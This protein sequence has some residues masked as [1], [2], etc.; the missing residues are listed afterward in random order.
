MAAER[1]AT[2]RPWE[3][4]GLTHE[5]YGRIEG[6]LGRPPNPV[7]LGLFGLMWSEHCSYK[8]SKSSLK[9]LPTRGP[10]VV[11]G[12]GENAGV[13]DIGDGIAVAFKIESHNHP[14]F[15]EPYQ[16]AA[17]GVGGILRDIFAM[18]ARPIAI[19]D[20]LR[21][22]ELDEGKNRWLFGGVVGGIGGYGNCFGCPTVGGE[23]YFEP[24]YRGNPLVNTMCVGLVDRDQVFYGRAEGEGN[25][26]ILVGS[27]TGRD[28]IHGASLLASKE[29]DERAEERRPAVQVGDP[30]LE[31]LLLEACLELLNTGAVVG[32]TD[33]GAAG[34]TSAAG[35]MASRGGHGL[36]IDLDKVPRRETGMTPYE[37]MLSESQ[38]RMLVVARAGREDD[39]RRVF[40]KWDLDAAVIGRV[41]AGGRLR[42]L[43]KGH[44]VADVP[45]AALAKDAPVYERPEAEPA[46]LDKTRAFDFAA[47]PVPADLAGVLVRLLAAPDI[48]D[49]SWVY[50]QYDHFIL[51]N[52]V[53]RP[54]SDAAVLR[55]KGTRRGLALT[56]DGNGRYVYLDPR[57][58]AAIAVA[59]A[60]RNVVCSGAEPLAVTN[61][62]NFGN[63]ERPEIMWQFRRTV[64]GLAEACRALGTPVTG[65][66]VSFY[67]ETLGE[68]IYPTPVIGLVGVLEDVE[69]D[70][71]T[72][73]FKDE[74]DL[75][76]LLGPLGGVPAV[77]L[78]GSE[79]LKVVHGLVAGRPPAL[80]LD[81]E[82][83]VHRACLRAIRAGLI[84]SAHDVSDGGLAVTLAEACF[85]GPG[86]N[87][88]VGAAIELPAAGPVAGGAA[89]DA[90]SGPA[91]RLDAIL[92][93]EDQSRIVVS[94][95]PAGA[96]RLRR[97][98][99]EEDAPLTVIGRVGGQALKIAVAGRPVIERPVAA[100]KKLWKE[101]IPWLMK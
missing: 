84:K 24:S 8:T 54:G 98:A 16:G 7:E 95:D 97:I 36:E 96:A 76:A 90:T 55:L 77:G 39:V 6:L 101:A 80:D 70:Q 29:F 83:R 57:A 15:I 4:V 51:T 100:L 69:R 48:A 52:T 18:G 87:A 94:L 32:L 88:P 43:E 91:A 3:E 40:A 82:A 35:E 64:E 10:R 44:V 58:G 22:G 31:K 33:L 89:G 47:L 14:S 67:N 92:F 86:E 27:K 13:V 5:E 42:V 46:Y 72:Q 41:T 9:K 50:Q 23:V 61:C 68:N 20:S 1:K 37:V 49:K 2:A 45:A 34:L 30:F 63:P 25:P 81:L 73:W 71:T 17:T 79:Y 78:G 93:G 62:L 21:F 53:V 75:V 38:E 59:E 28:G 12:P 56:T 74:G 85:G 60:A 66:N 11:Q 65:G 26:L 99:A 19:L